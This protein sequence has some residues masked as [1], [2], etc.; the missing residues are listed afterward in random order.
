M[1]LH[2]VFDPSSAETSESAPTETPSRR[3]AGHF[4]RLRAIAR[5]PFVQFLVLGAIIFLVVEHVE[6]QTSRYRVVIDEPV[7]Q[8]LGNAYQQQFGTMPTPLQ[9]R[10]LVDRYVRSEIYLR[11]GL[12]LGLDRDDEIIRRRIA[13]KYEFLQNDLAVPET[14]TPEALEA[15][16]RA[17]AARYTDPG[18]RSFTQ[19]YFSADRTGDA[20]ARLRAGQALADVTARGLT[21]APGVGDPFPGTPDSAAASR[22]DVERLFGGA[23]FATAVFKAP[24]GQWSGPYRSGWGWHL[25]RVEGEL[26]ARR[27]PYPEVADQVLRDYRE[28]ARQSA[29]DRAYAALQQQ[30]HVVRE[31]GPG[32]GR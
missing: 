10:E 12:A 22:A 21:R 7:I 24:I 25:V 20:D 8:R 1:G 19:I 28:D 17:N 2:V 29:N 23:D 11:E 3:P 27:R 9:M 30:Y 15:W 31:A 32:A 26:P 4:G 18:R 13:Q 14:P 16:Y 5:E 6:A